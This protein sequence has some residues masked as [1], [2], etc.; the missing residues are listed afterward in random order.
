MSK[1]NRRNALALV[2]SLPALGVPAA[3]AAAASHPDAELIALGDEL[4]ASQKAVTAICDRHSRLH[5][6]YEARRAP[7]PA[8]CCWRLGDEEI[9]GS[10]QK[11]HYRDDGMILP[12]AIKRLRE[13]GPER[14]AWDV[15]HL[16]GGDTRIIRIMRTNDLD[17]AREIVAAYDEWHAADQV[18]QAEFGMEN[19]DDE[20]AAAM[21]DQSAILDE[22]TA[23]PAHT[24]EGVKVKARAAQCDMDEYNDAFE[25]V[26]ALARAVLS[27][28]S[29][30]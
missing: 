17:R 25:I 22:I 26:D 19:W 12:H 3:V 29:A 14:E 15:Q 21:D 20:T 27:L 6:Q 5:K 7:L 13:L 4:A 9:I 18:L 16:F 2:A 10:V 1:L 24:L 23:T 11:E 8:V 28:S 30:A